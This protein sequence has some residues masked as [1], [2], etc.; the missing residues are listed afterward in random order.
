MLKVKAKYKPCHTCDWRY[1]KGVIQGCI[2]PNHAPVDTMPICECNTGLYAG[3][4]VIDEDYVLI[5]NIAEL[6]V[7]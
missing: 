4:V 5:K 7:L 2:F 6:V 3:N 1:E